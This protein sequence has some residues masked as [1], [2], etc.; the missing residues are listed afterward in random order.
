MHPLHAADLVQA[1][2]VVT[3]GDCRK[4][5]NG[6]ANLFDERPRAG[7]APATPA[8]DPG[9]PPLLRPSLE[10]SA[11]TVAVAAAPDEAVGGPDENVGHNAAGDELDELPLLPASRQQRRLPAVFWAL[12]AIALTVLLAYQGW[13]VYGHHQAWLEVEA[14]AATA[15][16]PDAFRLS[17]RDV[18]PHPSVADAQ[19]I[20]LR[21]R[22]TAL[23]PQPFPVVEIRLLDTTQN[24]VAIR[25]FKA[26][27]Y[28]PPGSHSKLLVNSGEDFAVMLQID[29]PM[30]GHGGVEF[31]IL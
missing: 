14:R 18:H 4:V 24:V 26:E 13:R 23:H 20:S 10:L 29:T 15:R 27:E 6:L 11:E 9:M 3:C 17:S 21:L 19:V 30:G 7:V 12:L 1:G 8:G 22:N 5:F 16:E 28:L 2:G 25:R 31:R